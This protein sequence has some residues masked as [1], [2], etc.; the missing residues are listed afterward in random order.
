M[1][2]H[3]SHKA[4]ILS[5]HVTDNPLPRYTRIEESKLA[6]LFAV[7][8]LHS[9]RNCW[10]NCKRLH[11]IIRYNTYFYRCQSIY[12]SPPGYLLL[13]LHETNW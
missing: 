7:H 11:T 12:S 10:A 9:P 13:P 1:I 6:I 8:L 5:K 4:S 2:N 3:V